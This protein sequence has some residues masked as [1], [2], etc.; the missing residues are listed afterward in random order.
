MYTKVIF[1]KN[2]E[3]EIEKLHI[4]TRALIDNKEKRNSKILQ[5]CWFK[6]VGES[7][8]EIIPWGSSLAFNVTFKE[9]F[10]PITESETDSKSTKKVSSG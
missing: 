5:F 2:C 1:E 10:F 4:I 9:E 7:E 3:N 6:F 8:N